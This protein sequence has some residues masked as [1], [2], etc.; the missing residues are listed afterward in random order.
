[1]QLPLRLISLLT[2]ASILTA[3]GGSGDSV[4]SAPRYPATRVGD[5]ATTHFGQRV[6]DPY[7]WLEDTS[8]Q[9]VRDWYGAQNLH[10]ESALANTASGEALT[11]A[12]AAD[13]A[14]QAMPRAKKGKKR[15][16]AQVAAKPNPK[17]AAKPAA[18]TA[19]KPAAQKPAAAA[20]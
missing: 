12:V 9:R 4:S 14:S 18:T 6:A 17:A 13:E 10:T 16:G 1:M 8:S 15:A 3:C 19:A 7:R 5:D 2:L 11:A 20:A